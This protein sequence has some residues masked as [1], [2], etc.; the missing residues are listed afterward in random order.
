MFL[1]YRMYWSKR[2]IYGT[3]KNSIEVFLIQKDKKKSKAT[4]VYLTRCH[5]GTLKRILEKLNLKVRM[6]TYNLIQ[7]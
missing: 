5:K 1:E 3:R 7:F 4:V 6:D 2:E